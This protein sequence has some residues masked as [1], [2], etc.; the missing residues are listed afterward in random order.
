[1][2]QP[3]LKPVALPVLQ[4]APDTPDFTPEDLE[5]RAFTPPP[6]RR[7]LWTLAILAVLI[8]LAVL[9][10]LLNV[11]RYQR[12]IV[13][14]ISQS[15]G[16]PVHAGEITLDLL[17]FPGFT[18]QN[19]TVSDDA[20]FSSEPVIRAGSVKARLRWRSLWH[21]RVEF[22]RITLSDASVNLVRRED[23]KWNLESI[24]LQASRMP[25]APTGQRGPGDRPR[26]PYIEATGAR[27]NLKMGLEKLPVSLTE[28]DF[29]LW[30][31]EPDRWRLRLEGHP[32]RTDAAVTDTGTFRLEGTLGRAATLAQ[33]PVDL[34]ASWTS[35]PLGA[36]SLV[37]LGHDAGFRGELTWNA[38]LQGT[39]GDNALQTRL[40]LDRVRRADFVPSRLLDIDLTCTARALGNLHRL[41]DLHCAWPTGTSDTGL[42][43][44]GEV[45]DT[46]APATANLQVTLQQF[47]ASGLL[48]V[49][50]LLTPRVA[51]ALQ[52]GGTVSA[53][54]TCCDSD[55]WIKSGHLEI[56][57][58]ALTLPNASP[59]LSSD[60]SADWKPG[61][62][63]QPGTLEMPSVPLDLGGTRPALLAARLSREGYN[64]QLTGPAQRT[65]LQQLATALPPFGDGLQD[66]YDPTQPDLLTLNCIAN[67]PW[68]GTQQ[69]Q[70][71]EI[72]QLPPTR[73]HHSKR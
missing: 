50:R 12:Q 72:L 3:S 38:A 52:L 63:G 61:P 47:S 59:F 19:F 26:F 40:Q 21:R 41:A 31:P 69:W 13:T 48:D 68:D 53:Q 16:R 66:F 44:M 17:P 5:P 33:V 55:D 57:Q 51:P 4:E 11:N 70:V 28:A 30:L 37:A 56:A 22:S 18:L 58:A 46:L 7:V 27:L 39:A 24:L 36:A 34:H 29:A 9:P 62:N 45:P 14:S 73:K 65:R 8:L 2:D 43:V 15:L 49:L 23:G 71:P 42:V 32:A 54:L 64:L 6:R 25:A 35:A 1:M 60:V 20:A 10:P 67:R